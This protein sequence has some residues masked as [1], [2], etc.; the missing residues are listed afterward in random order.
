VRLVLELEHRQLGPLGLVVHHLGLHHR[1]VDVGRADAKR[2]ARFHRQHPPQRD[3]G[4]GG[5]GQAV[6]GVAAALLDEELDAA[7]F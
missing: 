2:A 1:A 6:G 4:P 7:D 5:R 3:L